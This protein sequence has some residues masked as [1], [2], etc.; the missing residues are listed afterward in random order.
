MHH[1]SFLSYFQDSIILKSKLPNVIRFY[2]IPN[3][4]FNHGDYLWAKDSYD[5]LYKDVLNLID[6][7]SGLKA[8]SRRLHGSKRH[9]KV[10]RKLH[11]NSWKVTQ[12][13]SDRF[14]T[15]RAFLDKVS[16][17]C[18]MIL[19]VMTTVSMSL[20]ST[21]GLRL[22]QLIGPGVV[23]MMEVEISEVLRFYCM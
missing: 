17:F 19:P 9:S 13:W 10:K 22:F 2:E 14:S 20:C 4:K 7:Y 15:T 6:K 8:K 3:K 12:Q 18:V 5:L 1:P 16:S 11:G 23:E 21:V